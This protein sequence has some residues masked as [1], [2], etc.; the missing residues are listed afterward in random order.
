MTEEQKR[1]LKGHALTA[2]AAL[3]GPVL[4]ILAWAA[5]PYEHAAK[6]VPVLVTESKMIQRDVAA[7]KRD[8]REIL[9][10]L[11]RIEGYSKL[12]DG[13]WSTDESQESAR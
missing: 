12:I 4:M 10:R 2:L 7:L 9:Q 3:V 13:N 5:G 11:S 8:V 6:T 1:Q